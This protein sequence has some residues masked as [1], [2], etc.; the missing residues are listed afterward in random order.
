MAT[1]IKG[2]T[3]YIPALEPFKPDYKFL[4]DVLTVRQDRYDTN[5]K[6]LNDLYSK[7]VYAPLSRTDNSQ[8]RDQYANRL[9]NGLKQVSGLD[10]S[11]QQNVDVAKGL[12]KPFF[13]D[14]SL[15]KDMAATKLYANENQRANSYLNSPD[16]EIAKQYWDTGVQGL[17]MWMDKFKNASSEEALTMGMPQYVPNPDLYNLAFN[18]LKDSGLSIKQTTLDGDWI[19]TTQNGTALTRQ[20]TGY[21]RD[22]NDEL[23]KDPKT[24]QYIPIYNNPAAEYLMNTVMD[25]PQVKRAYLLEAQVKEWQWLKENENQYANVD[26]AKKAWSMEIIEKYADEETKKLIENEA[27]YKS[28]SIA[29]R[30]WEEWKK[31]NDVVPGSPEEEAMALIAYNQFIAKSNRD[32]NETRLKD[33]KGPKSDINQLL[34]T[35]YSAYMGFH[36]SPKMNAAAVAYSQIDASQTFEANPFRKME[37]KHNFDLNKMSIQHAYDMDKLYAKASSDYEIAKLKAGPG[38]GVNNNLLG[39][40]G[41][42]TEDG[43]A[44]ISGSLFGMDLNNDG[45]ID[46]SEMSFVDGFEENKQEINKLLGIQSNKN[47]AFIQEITKLF[48]EDSRG[49]RGYQGN[50]QF[51]YTFYDDSMNGQ[52]TTKTGSI[53]DMVFNLSNPENKYAQMN[54]TELDSIVTNFIDTY[55][56]KVTTKDGV[57]LSYKLP[58]ENTKPGSSL[59]LGMLYD[60]VIAGREL[61][62]NVVLEQNKVHKNVF[63]RVM[64]EDSQTYQSSTY[65]GLPNSVPPLFLT[66]GEID[67]MNQKIPWHKVNIAS[68]KGEIVEPIKDSNGQPIRRMVSEDE[69]AQI[70][71][72]MNSLTDDQRNILSQVATGYDIENPGSGGSPYAE[73]YEPPSTRHFANNDEDRDNYDFFLRVD[74]GSGDD[75]E[76]IAEKYW[77][78]NPD[79]YQEAYGDLE[80]GDWW[81]TGQGWTFDSNKAD[82]DARDYYKKFK[83]NMNAVMGSASAPDV[84]LNFSVASY[85][86]G[87]DQ[88]GLGETSYPI[89]TTTFDSGSMTAQS[90]QQVKELSNTF[91]KVPKQDL[92]VSFGDNRALPSND[93]R[94]VDGNELASK[95]VNAMLLNINTGFNDKTQ[96]RPYI[97]TSYVEKSGGP[98][99]DRDNPIFSTHIMPGPMHAEKYKGFFGDMTKDENKEAFANFMSSGITVTAPQSYDN[100]PYRST[101]VMMSDV[102]RVIRNNNVYT[103]PFVQNGGEFSIYKDSNGQYIQEYKSYG[104]KEVD[105]GSGNKIKVIAPDPVQTTTLNIVDPQQLDALKITLMESL[106]IIAKNNINAKK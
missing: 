31:H 63:D 80:M 45:V 66:Q 27:Q 20:I 53:E 40:G 62:T 55:Q 10:L 85:M 74:R 89:Y 105:D 83:N 21:K 84:E 59:Q 25:D 29:L 46:R 78:W 82:L 61:I 33:L 54:S 3:D 68:Q 96:S 98:D 39:I 52:P 57:V 58:T 19:V 93:Q 69:F 81:T 5:Y 95:V 99:Q 60:D 73:E 41:V 77:S 30:N 49:V 7:V 17:S 90:L 12:F 101:N 28:E 67:M 72:N 92:I 9:S 36:M 87:Q 34:T 14:K 76:Y 70:Y 37:M 97:T 50:G 65:D 56:Q 51:E 4:S 86:Q 23:I 18:S 64:A 48:P 104:L 38:G 94:D 13:E 43:Q 102:E 2:V 26:E 6:Q 71:I 15:I 32:A 88:L 100:N 79:R 106:N 75:A 47:L 1:Y 22:E 11:L 16:K 24:D 44:N 35:A 91:F 103:S 42:I 8:R